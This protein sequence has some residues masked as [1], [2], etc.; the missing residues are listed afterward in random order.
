QP[1]QKIE[2]GSVFVRSCDQKEFEVT[3]RSQWTTIE[4]SDG[5]KD[6]IKHLK[7]TLFVNASNTYFYR[8]YMPEE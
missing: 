5:E 8:A 6:F 2:I 4:S 7:E 3:Y 1:K